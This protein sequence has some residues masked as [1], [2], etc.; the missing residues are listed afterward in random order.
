MELMTKLALSA[1]APPI[2][3]NSR[4]GQTIMTLDER[5]AA[6]E[7]IALGRERMHEI[8]EY[9]AA[10]PT[11]AASEPFLERQVRYDEV[12]DVAFSSTETV[13]ALGNRLSAEGPWAAMSDVEVG[14]LSSWSNSIDELYNIYQ[15]TRP[16]PYAAA[17]L[18]GA[19]ATVAALYFLTL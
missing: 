19:L 6:L 5:N 11:W 16:D 8:V 17:R 7:R 13:I 14:A 18:G 10:L 12:L 9:S 1:W 4:L 3:S 15:T 2:H